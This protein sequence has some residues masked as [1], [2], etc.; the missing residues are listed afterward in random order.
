M[1]PLATGQFPRTA[2]LA[3]DPAAAALADPA[4]L[5]GPFEHGL[6]LL[7]DRAAAMAAGPAG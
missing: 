7:L 5:E 4:A 2:A 3:G 6:A 1:V